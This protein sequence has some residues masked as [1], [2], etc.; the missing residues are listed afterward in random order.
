MT[1]MIKLAALHKHWCIADAVRVVVDAPILKPDAEAETIKK[2]GL[3]FAMLGQHASMLAR[4]SVWYS[5]LYVV[6][7]GYRDLSVAFEPL[8]QVLAKE[9]YI[10]LLRLFRNATFHYQEDPL[11]KKLIGFLDKPD[12]EFW[13]RELNKQLQAFFTHALPINDVLKKMERHDA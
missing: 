12:S 11:S 2:F 4:M 6:V 5:L 10:D 9:G 7:E 1:D 3:E 13:I 8:D